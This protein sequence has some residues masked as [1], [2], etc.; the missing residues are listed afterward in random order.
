MELRHLRYFVAVAEEGHVRRA[1]A[2]LGIQQPPLTQQIQALEAQLG[3]QLFWRSPGKIG[4]N[5]AGKV[6]LQDARRILEAADAAARRVREFDLGLDGTLRVGL[7]SSSLLHPRTQ[8]VIRRLRA[9]YANIN[10]QIEE[11]SARELLDMA[12][13]DRLDVVFV[14]A[15]TQGHPGLTAQW[16]A[17]E[18]MVL[19]LPGA[20]PLG[21]AEDIPLAELQWQNLILYRQERWSGIGE[22]VLARCAA[23]GFRPRIVDETRRLIPAVN[24]VAAG[25][26]VTVVPKSLQ[27]FQPGAVLYRPLAVDEPMVAPLN[28]VYRPEQSELPALARLLET[29]AQIASD[30]SVAHLLR[31]GIPPMWPSPDWPRCRSDALDSEP[32]AR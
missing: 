31:G 2:R 19:A 30:A 27:T 17:E 15:G 3:V 14:R 18:E 23:A 26:G 32:G 7:T 16:L 12:Q 25:I 8:A 22:M 13:A 20:H 4:L 10:L 5:A 1:A 29:G 21:Q 28:M 24:L 6:F 9:E 11:G